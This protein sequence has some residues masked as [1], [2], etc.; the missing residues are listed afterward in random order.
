MF[1]SANGIMKMQT[2]GALE[3]S[4]EV[5]RPEV[6]ARSYVLSRIMVELDLSCSKGL[7]HP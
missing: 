5:N 3:G 7:C 6:E 2:P 1:A 4:A